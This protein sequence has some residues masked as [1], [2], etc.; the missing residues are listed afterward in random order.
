ME[1]LVVGE[2][3]TITFPFSDLSGAKRRPALVVASLPGNDVILCQITSRNRPDPWAVEINPN[4]FAWGALPIDSLVRCSKLFTADA[5]IVE[6][7]LGI[8]NNAT[9]E[10]IVLMAQSILGQDLAD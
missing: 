10:K 3:V 1:K 9:L 7:K 8:L 2:V 5:N 6:R 4:S